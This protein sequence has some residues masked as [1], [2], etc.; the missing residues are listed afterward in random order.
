MAIH[1]NDDLKQKR[2]NAM[3]DHLGLL[4]DSIYNEVIWIHFKWLEYEELYG[5][6]E[7]RIEILNKSAAWFFF[8][9]QR[10]L[11]HDILLD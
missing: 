4:Y 10:T 2:I 3:G 9:I 6:S 7:K 1:T 11:F 8:I 5:R